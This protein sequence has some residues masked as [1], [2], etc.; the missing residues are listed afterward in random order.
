VVFLVLVVWFAAQAGIL[1]ALYVALLCAVAFDYYFLPPV[2]TLQIV[3]I[4]QWVAMISFLLSC[5]VVGRLA[6]RARG[7][8]RQA[9]ARR[10]D[11]ERL[12]SLS[13]EMMLHED[14]AGLIRDLP[15]LIDRIFA[16]DGVVLYICDG[17]QL[18]AS[19][20]ELPIS[21]QASLRAMPHSPNPSLAIP[22]GFHAMTLMLGLR[23]VGALGWRPSRLSREVASAVSAQVAIVLARSMAIEASVRMEA[24]REGERLR[25]AL[26]DSLTHELRTPLTSIRAAATTLLESEGLDEAGRRE[27]AAIVDEEASRLD[28]LIGQA[29]AAGRLRPRIGEPLLVVAIVVALPTLW[30][31]ALSTLAALIPLLAAGAGRPTASPASALPASLPGPGGPAPSATAGA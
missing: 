6:A 13:Q 22:G 27:L 10:E 9:E 1:L 2:R 28:A 26:I 15:R 16:L 31:T 21:I 12:Y 8:A 30:F 5:A 23:P 29:V 24:A 7:Q 20:S 11:M 3:G 4:Q 19:T 18:Y 25:T 14:A 17:D